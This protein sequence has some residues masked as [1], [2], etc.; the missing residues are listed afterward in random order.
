MVVYQA[1]VFWV[2]DHEKRQVEIDPDMWE[3]T[4]SAPALGVLAAGVVQQVSES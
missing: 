1:L 4:P 3:S 2:K